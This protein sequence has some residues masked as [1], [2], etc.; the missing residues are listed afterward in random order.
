MS[1]YTFY[2][3]RLHFWKSYTLK[4]NPTKRK[5]IFNQFYL[6]KWLH[7]E[8]CNPKCN[9]KCNH[10]ECLQNGSFNTTV[11]LVT[12][13]FNKFSKTLF[14]KRKEEKVEK[15]RGFYNIYKSVVKSVTLRFENRI[16]R[17]LRNI[18]RKNQSVVI[19]V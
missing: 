14:I 12:L 3:L 10:R 5:S 16:K 18:N 17:L 19:G 1:G 9:Q 11:T 2:T 7:F 4:C 8:K 6:T 15:K 13:F